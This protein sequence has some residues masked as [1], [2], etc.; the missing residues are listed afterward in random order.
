MRVLVVG[1]GHA[2]ARHA[3]AA[4]ALGHDAAALR[5]AAGPAPD[6]VAVFADPAGA[7]AWRPD[8][9]V[10]ATP[11]GE[12]LAGLRWAVEHELPVLVEKPLADRPDGVADLL[13]AATVPI[14][15]AYNLRFHPALE[16][17][18]EAIG[19]GRIGRLLAARAEV[20]Q[21]LP[22]WHPGEDHRP[23]AGALLELSHEL[24]LVRWLGGEVAACSGVRARVSDLDLDVEDVAEVVCRHESGA[25]SSVHVDFVDRSYN[26]RSRWIGS[27][28]SIEWRWGGPVA[29]ER[30][31]G[32]EL[33]WQD[34][35]YDPAET[36]RAQLADFLTAAAGGAGP[37][38]TGADG[39]RVVELAAAVG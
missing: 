14:G 7:L 33:L 2:G 28:A 12:H 17:V 32:R 19:A 22:D 21:Y 5:R 38:V 4:L 6:G 20:G 27:D 30:G 18:A 1:L 26:R 29:L 24:D 31:A 37:R 39:L 25:V 15:V 3:R 36:Y 9:A 16:T 10:I 8:A 13:A 23:G 34:D 35:G 11:A